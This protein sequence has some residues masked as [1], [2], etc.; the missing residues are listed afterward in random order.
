MCEEDG[1]EINFSSLALASASSS[2]VAL[3][4]SD[5]GA[6][7][8]TG[9]R[10]LAPARAQRVETPLDKLLSKTT[11]VTAACCKLRKM[12]LRDFNLVEQKTKKV[13]DAAKSLLN[14]DSALDVGEEDMGRWRL[15][16]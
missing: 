15:C 1:D 11:C 8:T 7:R 6:S 4:G 5:S 12:S 16:C 3:A 10:Q 9:R 2:G 13:C 14:I